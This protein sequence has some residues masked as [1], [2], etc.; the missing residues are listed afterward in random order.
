VI[1]RVFTPIKA[2]QIFKSLQIG[3]QS[4][5]EKIHCKIAKQNQKSTAKN[6]RQKVALRSPNF[7]K[8][9]PPIF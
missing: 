1:V 8:T 4:A 7:Q 2:L 6:Q 3:L 9:K 5:R